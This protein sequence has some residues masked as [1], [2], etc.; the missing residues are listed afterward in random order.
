MNNEKIKSKIEIFV[1]NHGRDDK[2]SCAEKG[3]KE[4][5]DN[6]KKWAKEETDKQVRVFRSGCLGKCSE[7]IA[8]AFYPEKKFLLD[9]E[10]DDEKK[11]KKGL[12]EALENLK[13]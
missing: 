7:G 8:I 5:T 3:A 13:D 6:L 10:L 12:K 4:L 1:C 2:E 9:V 11:I